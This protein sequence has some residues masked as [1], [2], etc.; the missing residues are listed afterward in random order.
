MRTLFLIGILVALVVIANKRPDQS[1]GDA[2]RAFVENA[3]TTAVDLRDEGMAAIKAQK[4]KTGIARN[5]IDLAEQVNDEIRAEDTGVAINPAKPFAPS[6]PA[7][8]VLAEPAQPQDVAAAPKEMLPDLPVRE[9]APQRL[10]DKKLTLPNG[11]VTARPDYADV[12]VLY[13]N[14]ARLLAEIK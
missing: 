7:D 14:A 10:D 2:A 13:E 5:L 11:P 4:D 3:K 1:T 6:G 8:P 9:V 12:K